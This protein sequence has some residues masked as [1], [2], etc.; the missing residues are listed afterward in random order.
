ML[1]SMKHHP[2]ISAIRLSDSERL[3]YLPMLLSGLARQVDWQDVSSSVTRSVSEYAVQR[4]KKGYTLGMINGE[5]AAIM[6]DGNAFRHF[7]G[8]LPHGTTIVS[9]TC[10]NE[11]GGVDTE[12]LA[13]TVE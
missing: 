12:Q 8:P 11:R 13:V 3:D 7:V 2:Q 10:Q 5:P 9:I 1:D 6:F 4:K